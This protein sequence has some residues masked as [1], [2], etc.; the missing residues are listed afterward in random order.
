MINVECA[1]GLIH[2]KGSKVS[3]PNEHR[4]MALPPPLR[5]AGGSRLQQKELYAGRLES[6]ETRGLLTSG[7]GSEGLC[8]LYELPALEYSLFFPLAPSQEVGGWLLHSSFH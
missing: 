6:Q 2:K 5:Q 4:G 3:T 1:S 7:F 8:D